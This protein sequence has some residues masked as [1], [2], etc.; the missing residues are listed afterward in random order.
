[1]RKTQSLASRLELLTELPVL[2][3]Y[4]AVLRTRNITSA[5][6]LKQFFQIENI[7]ALILIQK[8]I[9]VSTL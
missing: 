6:Y 9:I 2:P 3:L 4:S 1:M 8:E 7:V 5:T